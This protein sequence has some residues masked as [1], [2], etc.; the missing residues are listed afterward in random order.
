VVV[1][2][3]RRDKGRLRAEALH[4]F[5][6]KDPA[7]EAQRSIEVGNFQVDV[8][9]P[10]PRING[11]F[12]LPLARHGP[13]TSRVHGTLLGTSGKWMREP[14]ARFVLWYSG[15]PSIDEPVD[16]LVKI[17][18]PESLSTDPLPR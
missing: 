11:P 10:R 18:S 8:P 9:N 16:G 13:Q 6:A 3:A 15:L 12:R 5:E 17:V 4:Q 14:P 1:L 7:V 2:A